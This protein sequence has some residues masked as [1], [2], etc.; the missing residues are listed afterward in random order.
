[1]RPDSRGRPRD[2]RTR[3]AL[4]ALVK[5]LIPLALVVATSLAARAAPAAASQRALEAKD[6]SMTFE[7]DPKE[8]IAAIVVTS[9]ARDAASYAL[10]A[11]T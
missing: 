8:P 9:E 3:R 7:L 1:M 11:R 10:F 2:A 4:L 5:L 6:P